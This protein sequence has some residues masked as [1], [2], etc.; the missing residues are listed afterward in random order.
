MILWVA[1]MCAYKAAYTV[2]VHFPSITLAIKQGA[3]VLTDICSP[4]VYMM[5]SHHWSLGVVQGSPSAP[6]LVYTQAVS[7]HPPPQ[8]HRHKGPSDSL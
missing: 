4:L 1:C 8:E 6:P 7:P 5:D 2:C 3:V